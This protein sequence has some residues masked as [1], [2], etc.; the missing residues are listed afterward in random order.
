LRD[1][2]TSK[3]T[4]SDAQVDRLVADQFDADLAL[5]DGGTTINA[6]A[7]GRF[8]TL[9]AA[10]R[11]GLDP[12]AYT[13]I[14]TALAEPLISKIVPA[15]TGNAEARA[16]LEAAGVKFDENGM[17]V[18]DKGSAV[19]E[20]LGLVGDNPVLRD[21]S[22]NAT[23]AALGEGATAE[24]IDA[25]ISLATSGA[26]KDAFLKDVGALRA[27][28]AEQISQLETLGG[29]AAAIAFLRSFDLAL[30]AIELTG[31]DFSGTAISQFLSSGSGSIGYF[32]GQIGAGDAAAWSAFTAD[33]GT[34]GASL[35]DGQRNTFLEQA[36]GISLAGSFL[37]LTGSSATKPNDAL[38]ISG[39]L[40]NIVSD[41]MLAAAGEIPAGFESVTTPEFAV[42]AGFGRLLGRYAEGT[43]T[44]ADDVGAVLLGKGLA[45]VVC[46]QSWR[47]SGRVWQGD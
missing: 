21:P 13:T 5:L 11:N 39:E 25:A 29:N 46:L 40:L 16:E 14:T 3:G 47:Y 43:P 33:L 10:D 8:A 20:V 41:G 44:V 35:T 31:A 28:V 17:I 12:N 27:Q 42:G 9:S 22:L 30:G 34:F 4:Y 37:T 45:S 19:L 23:I 32:L 2:L 15:Q 1:T 38:V 18:T 36:Y 7:Q 6:Y 26:D 24:Q